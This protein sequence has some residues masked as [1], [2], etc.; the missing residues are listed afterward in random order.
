[1]G[2]HH[3]G[4]GD[5]G[6]GGSST[7]SVTTR[8]V[9][10]A[11]I[12]AGLDVGPAGADNEWG[13]YTS[14]AFLTARGRTSL[15]FV[16]QI[17]PDRHSVSMPSDAW[18]AI[19]TLP[20]APPARPGT[21]VPRPGPAPDGGSIGPALDPIVLPDS[22]GPNLLPWIIGGIALAGI[23]AYFYFTPGKKARP[24]AANRRRRGV[25]AN[26]G[27]T[28]IVYVD[29]EEVGIIKAGSHNAAEK[30]AQKM[31]PGRQVSVSYTEI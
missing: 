1:M 5:V 17:A 20:A 25:R 7:I 8:A 16:Y 10:Q 3:T 31:Y 29:G 22:S 11:L 2:Y 14:S 28:Y 6:I 21:T 26:R 30:K 4:T 13:G 24:V 15:P 27:K 23:G 9:Q 18:L 12:R 19:Q